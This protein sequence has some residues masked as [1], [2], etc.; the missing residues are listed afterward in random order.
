MDGIHKAIKRTF[1]FQAKKFFIQFHTNFVKFIIGEET[2]Q[3]VLLKLLIRTKQTIDGKKLFAPKDYLTYE[4]I[5]AAFSWM[6]KHRTGK[7]TKPTQKNKQ[8]ETTFHENDDPDQLTDISFH[9]IIT[10]LS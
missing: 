2:G 3:K 4:Q 10:F 1:Y 6:A 7:L 8:V 5:T 9:V